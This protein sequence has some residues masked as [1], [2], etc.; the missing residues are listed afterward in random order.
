MSLSRPTTTTNVGSMRQAAASGQGATL[1]DSARYGGESRMT[2][3]AT[4]GAA[5]ADVA[6]G[7]MQMGGAW[8]G[9]DK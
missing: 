8:L 5:I 9:R 7:M 3:A 2:A 1:M 4:E 6:G